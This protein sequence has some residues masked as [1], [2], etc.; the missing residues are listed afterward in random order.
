MHDIGK[1]K[2]PG[3]ILNK[4]GKYND[5]EFA[6][7]QKHVGFTVD[8]LYDVPHI[9]EEVMEIAWSHH[10]KLDGTGYPRGL[11]NGQI[12]KLARMATIVD[13]FTALNDRRVYKDAIPPDDC[14]KIMKGMTDDLDMNL[15]E[16]FIASLDK[17]NLEA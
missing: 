4:P 7:M 14:I 6:E 9:D 8:L 15:M 5:A 2:V 13:I 17:I 1:A 11:K 10:E 16:A 3:A 12:S